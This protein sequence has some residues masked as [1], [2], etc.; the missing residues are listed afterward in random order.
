MRDGNLVIAAALDHEPRQSR[1][2]ALLV[3]GRINSRFVHLVDLVD[4][5]YIELPG[6]VVLVVERLHHLVFF[7]PLSIQGLVEA[8][9]FDLA[10]E[11]LAVFPGLLPLLSFSQERG[12]L[13]VHYNLY[14]RHGA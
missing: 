14:G 4:L 11:L 10:L 9:L 8:H 7:A 5:D 12:R 13:A 1:E 2:R 3:D 6:G